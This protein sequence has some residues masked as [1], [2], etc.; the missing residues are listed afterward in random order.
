MKTKGIRVSVNTSNFPI[1][2][3]G[4][5]T[6]LLLWNGLKMGRGEQEKEEEGNFQFHA[7]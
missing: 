7:I 1:Q 3:V 6:T 4:S 2:N 5:H